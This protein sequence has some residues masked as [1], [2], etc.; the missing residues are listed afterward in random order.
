MTHNAH[1]LLNSKKRT[2]ASLL[3]TAFY[4]FTTMAT[5][6]AD[7]EPSVITAE[8]AQ[9]THLHSDTYTKIS[10]L[11]LAALTKQMADDD[12][13]EEKQ[14][15]ELLKK[16]GSLS[17]LMHV[18]LPGVQ[19]TEKLRL[20]Y[21][22][23][24][25]Y[26]NEHPSCYPEILSLNTI[27]DLDLFFNNSAT[28]P[29]QN[30]FSYLDKTTTI[31]GKIQLQKLLFTPTNDIQELS[32]RQEIIRI[33]INDEGLLQELSVQLQNIARVE[34]HVLWFWKSVSQ[35]LAQFMNN[36]NFPD[37]ECFDGLNE[38]AKALQIR[39]MLSNLYSLCWIIG[40]GYLA[41]H[42]IK[43]FSSYSTDEQI[44]KSIW[45]VFLIVAGLLNIYS[46]GLTHHIGCIKHDKINNIAILADATDG[47]F[48]AIGS[49]QE[50]D[51][52]FP[53]QALLIPSNTPETNSLRSLL[54]TNTLHSDPGVF[55]F[56]GNALAAFNL[57]N[58]V[59]NDFAQTLFTI[60]QLD[61]YVSIAKLYKQ[62]QNHP[63]VNFCFAQYS[64]EQKP[65]INLV[66][67]WHPQLNP[68]TVIT[69]NVELGAAYGPRDMVITGPNA[70][71]KSTTLKAIT[72]ALLL[73]HSFGIAPA[74]AC[75]I[76][77]FAK[78]NTY[79]NIA[80]TT[81]SA[82]LFQAEM[83]R[84]QTL[85]NAL[86]SSSFNDFS[87][88][89]MD[90]I[91]TGTNAKE[92]QAGAYGVAKKLSGFDNSIC[93]FATHFKRLT[94]LEAATNGIIENKK[95]MVI[96][97]TDGSFT[98][99]YKL[100]SGITDQAIAID[101]LKQEGFDQEILDVAHEILDTHDTN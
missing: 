17:E 10:E 2:I 80:D 74:N 43:N 51:A 40:E 42:F 16:F 78:I 14:N 27:K 68:E 19:A 1:T 36:T 28:S 47:L 39:Q 69:N 63:R 35:I 22:I 9:N 75:T 32:H 24:A 97:N 61:A 3:F 83:R 48:Q 95:V 100:E 52:L 34:A 99:P 88:I 31:F 94:E 30:V 62:F 82:S 91:F 67:F 23:F 84:T 71:G 45:T 11:Y 85:I 81:G 5:V 50:L 26:E 37:W 101:L 6:H 7:A 89:V 72:I 33:L 46:I 20:A 15:A 76:T 96:K 86:K 12:K 90:E 53:S 41:T 65:Y 44:K 57:M 38:S 93:L 55:T 66:N 92:G 8:S 56:Q 87:F 70:G 54:L 60:G 21:S 77:P 98:F 29:D 73:A 59:K 64:H 18:S 58:K 25:E 49:N 4:I 13:N 79:M